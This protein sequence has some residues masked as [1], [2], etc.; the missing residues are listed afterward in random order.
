VSGMAS[1]TATQPY[2]RIRLAIEGRIAQLTLE[3][4][5]KLNALDP[6]MLE[7]LLDALPRVR[8]SEASVLVLGASGRAFC[9]GV[10]LA[11]PFFM[12][13]VEADSAFAG[14]RLLEWQHELIQAIYDLPQVTVCAVNGDAVGGGGFG[15]AMACDLRFAA[16]EARFWM[17]PIKVD[18]VQDFGLTWLLQRAIGQPRTMEMLMTGRAIGAAEAERW[19]IVNAVVPAAELRGAVMNV[20]TTV[21][22]AGHDAVRLSKQVVRHGAQVDLRTELHHEAVTNGLCFHSAEFQARQRAFRDRALGSGGA[23]VEGRSA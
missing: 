13:G 19:G 12:E 14:Q 10:D 4:P 9:A 5:G 11:S 18:V 23:P 21:A 16:P 15:M 2:E 22:A 7:E 8:R 6:V 20:A 17:I 1:G 3:R